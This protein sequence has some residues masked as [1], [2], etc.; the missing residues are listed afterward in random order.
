MRSSLYCQLVLENDS[1]WSYYAKHV[2]G[3]NGPITLLDII[4]TQTIS[5]MELSLKRKQVE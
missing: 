1:Y 2:V 5:N 4:L 3:L